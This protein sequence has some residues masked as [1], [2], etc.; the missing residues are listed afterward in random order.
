MDYSCS[1]HFLVAY[2]DHKLGMEVH[3]LDC[4]SVVS[5]TDFYCFVLINSLASF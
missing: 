4:L 5:G 3:Y 1:K 2:L